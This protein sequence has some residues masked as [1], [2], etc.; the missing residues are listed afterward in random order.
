MDSLS[1]ARQTSLVPSTSCSTNRLVWATFRT[2]METFQSTILTVAESSA[3][4]RAQFIRRTYAHLAAAVLAFIGI[5]F[6]LFQTSLP[7]QFV[8]LLGTS[9]YG[10]LIVLAAFMGTSWVAQRMANS[11]SSPA[12][13]YLGLGTYVVAEAFLFAPMLYLAA[14]YSGP[15]T[16]P[17]AGL[18]TVMLFNGLSFVVLTTR[19]DFS[20]LGGI[21]K[22]G[23]FVALGVIGAGIVFGFNL[24]LFFSSVMVLFAAGAILYDTSNVVH[25]YGTRQHVAAALSLFASVALLFWYILRIVMS[26]SGRRD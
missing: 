13:Q 21:L 4:E 9:K 17:I 8:G 25:R 3:V 12:L 23:S 26:V 18:L 11:D 24:G 15:S 7:Q 10:W 5:E 14:A 6:L 19:K 1:A 2:A 16:I 22:V 20:F